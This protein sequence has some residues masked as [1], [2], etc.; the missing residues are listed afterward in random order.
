[1]FLCFGFELYFSQLN[2]ILVL[3][4]ILFSFY[5]YSDF[6]S[7]MLKKFRKYLFRK[8]CMFKNRNEV[9][10]YNVTVSITFGN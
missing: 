9:K 3:R 4:N 10:P 1:M 5:F 6:T 8:I 2:K 7:I